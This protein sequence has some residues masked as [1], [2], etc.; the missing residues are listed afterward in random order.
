MVAEAVVLMGSSQAHSSYVLVLLT[1]VTIMVEMGV[2]DV[3]LDT[4]GAD[5]KLVAL[6]EDTEDAVPATDFDEAGGLVA[7]TEMTA[8]VINVVAQAG[9]C[10]DA[11]LPRN[12]TARFE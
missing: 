5:L 11:R 4:R 12:M 3:E 6:V 10:A 7:K 1:T 9:T 2:C 8:L